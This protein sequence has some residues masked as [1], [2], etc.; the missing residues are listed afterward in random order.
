MLF[1]TKTAVITRGLSGSG[2]STFAKT[3]ANEHYD[4]GYSVAIHETDRFFYED[5][6]YTFNPD[7]L[8]EYHAN[9]FSDFTG[10]IKAGIHLVINSNT[11][12]QL[13]EYV[14]YV[15][16]AVENGY[17]I[18]VYDIYDGGATEEQLFERNLHGFPLEKY[19]VMKEH[20]ERGFSNLD[21]RPFWER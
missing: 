5:G 10:S 3:I 1:N 17:A 9:N 4:A 6:V 21:P 2:K 14:N 19:K 15:N 20:Y 12:S 18:L 7:K 8:R 16:V 11:N 13:W